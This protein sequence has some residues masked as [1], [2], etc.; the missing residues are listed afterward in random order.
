MRIIFAGT[1]DFSVAP[2]QALIASDNEVV[3]VYS[4]PDR[5]AGRGRKLTSS[6]VK[7]VALDHDIP[8]YQPLNFKAGEDMAQL[9]TLQA[10]LMVVVAYGLLLPQRVLDA[11]RLGCINIHAS[12]LP[13]W[14]GAAPIQRAI[15]AGDGESGITIMQMEAGL[16]TGPMHLVK[17]CPIEA[18][19]TGSSLH[20]K[21]MQLGA[22]ALM[23]ALPLVERGETTPET[24]DDAQATY[25]H[26]LKKD[27]ARIDWQR[28]AV[29]IDRLV[30]AFNAWPVA[31]T[32]Y[33]SGML[34]IWESA[35]IESAV[36]ADPGTVVAEGK[37]GIDVATG[38]GLLRISRLQLP[39]K[40]AM[41][42]ADFINAHSLKGEIFA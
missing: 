15:A 39:G 28:P 23:E 5:P 40:R 3:A 4:Q 13:R 42:V 36:D 22:D 32:P 17:R 25:A 41:G 11:P 1:P 7:Q 8:V 37:Q 34:R 18:G 21:L 33:A 14:R 9:E 10:D 27:E 38:D 19:E 35:P 31:Q 12:I 30:R 2:L 6:P 24:Q 26:K 16:D 29:E 20:D